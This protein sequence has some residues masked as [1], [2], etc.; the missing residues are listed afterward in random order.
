M[1]LIHNLKSLLVQTKYNILESGQIKSFSP[2]LSDCIDIILETNNNFICFKDIWTHNNLTQEIL[3]CYL[4]E[5]IN[6][7]IKSNTT[8]GKKFIFVLLVKNTYVNYDNNILNIKNIHIIKKIN[9]NKLIKEISYFLY[10]NNIFYFEPD[11]SI[12][13]LE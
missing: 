7:I 10:S 5:Q 8:L 6:S 3:D 9:K 1:N 13:M 11:N 12:I 4:S 2:Q